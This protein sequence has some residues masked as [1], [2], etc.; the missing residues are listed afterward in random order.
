MIRCPVTSDWSAFYSIDPRNFSGSAAQKAR[1]LGGE[2]VAW[3]DNTHLDSSTLLGA[4]FPACSSVAEVLWSPA[5]LTATGPTAGT[6]ERLLD[7]RCRL[8]A[9]GIPAF[10]PANGPGV[11]WSGDV[12]FCPEEFAAGAAKTDDSEVQASEHSPTKNDDQHSKVPPAPPPGWPGGT[13]PDDPSLLC[14][15][16]SAEPNWPRFHI[17]NNVSRSASGALVLAQPGDANAIFRYGGLYHAMNQGGGWA[18]AVSN[19]LVH[20][21]H[22][23]EAL[24]DWRSN[25]SWDQV[26]CD[27]TVSFPDLGEPPFNGSAPVI[28]YGPDCGTPVPKPN[29]SAAG[30]GLG[31]ADAPRVGTAR[32]AVP[33]SPYLLDWVKPKPDRPVRF[34]GI[35]CSFPG[36][37]WK[38]KIKNDTWNML[39]AQA[40]PWPA[41]GTGS[42]AG[43]WMKYT[44]HAKDLLTWKLDPKPFSQTPDGKPAPV[45]PCSMG[46]VF[47]RHQKVER[48]ERTCLES[49]G[50]RKEEGLGVWREEES[51][52]LGVTQNRRS[53]DRAVTS[54]ASRRIPQPSD[55]SSQ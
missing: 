6:Y 41:G 44:S 29:G 24:A 42:N 54:R 30:H 15:P 3:N 45:Y 9:R 52:L 19:D 14:Q 31:S 38:S 16:T 37:V 36:R 39:C 1:V 50:G 23:K 18:H 17:V 7:H 26:Q 28:M 10:V 20:W 55:M 46:G 51:C 4:L 12:G 8:V 49:G 5:E 40:A 22:V 25:P 2:C 13:V 35:P 48:R 32:A 47:P 34:E 43:A 21:H 33:V 27:G 53:G 11:G